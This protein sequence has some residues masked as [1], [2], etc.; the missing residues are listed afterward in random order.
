[1]IVLGFLNLDRNF[2]LRVSHSQLADF[3]E[4]CRGS[5]E[6]LGHYGFTKYPSDS[7]YQSYANYDSDQSNSSDTR[8]D[9]SRSRSNSYKRSDYS[10]NSH[11]TSDY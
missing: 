11:S 2:A 9:S 1:M 5:Y 3:Q 6:L 10:Q 8:L 4:F 7:G